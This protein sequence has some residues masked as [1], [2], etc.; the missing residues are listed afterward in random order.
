MSDLT[1]EQ[2]LQAL[3]DA[4]VDVHQGYNGRHQEHVLIAVIKGK[5]HWYFNSR[6]EVVID[7][8][9]RDLVKK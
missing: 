3:I 9:W 2:K 1:I 4:G 5:D 7:E 6:A 8:A